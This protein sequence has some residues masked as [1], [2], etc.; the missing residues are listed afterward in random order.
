MSYDKI[1]RRDRYL[2]SKKRVSEL[3]K[4]WYQK[5]KKRKQRIAKIWAQNHRKRIVEIV[6]AYVKRNKEKVANYNKSFDQTIEGK[7]RLLKF[8][9]EKRWKEQI[10]SLEDFA[11]MIKKMCSYCGGETSKGIDRID[12]MKGYTKENSTSCCKLCNFMKK[13]LT[14][15]EFISHIKKIYKYN[16]IIS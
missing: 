14:K 5:N 12:N 7:Y 2:Q 15:Q 11:E 6:Q 4:I 8:R 10:L 16:Q 1:K 9:H 3:G 13:A